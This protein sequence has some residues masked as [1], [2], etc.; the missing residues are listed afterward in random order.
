MTVM[1]VPFNVQT[2]HSHECECPSP[3]FLSLNVS[4]LNM[5]DRNEILY[6]RQIYTHRTDSVVILPITVSTSGRVY[7]DF[8]RL[9]FLHT[10]REASILSVTIPIDL[11]TCPFIPLP[12]FFN[13]RRLKVLSVYC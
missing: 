13:S 9:F 3:V 2:E 8:T 6:Y 7:E 11:S 5:S 1:D 10:C 4:R 12:R